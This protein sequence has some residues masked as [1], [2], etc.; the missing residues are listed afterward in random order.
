V[1]SWTLGS[2]AG[3]NTL[4]A[5]A[6]GLPSVT[7]TATGTVADTSYDIEI[8]VV[9]SMSGAVQAAFAAAEAKWESVITGDLPNINLTAAQVDACGDVTP[10]DA[11]T[12]D[13]LV[14]YARV[15][16]IDGVGKILGQAGPCYIRSIGKLPILGTMEFDEADMAAMAADGILGEVILHEM[17]HVLG[18]GTV[19]DNLSLLQGAGTADPYFSGDQAKAAYTGLGGTLVNG[20][21]LESTGEEGTR[22]SH[23][24]ETTF[25]TE[26]MTGWI[27][28]A[29]NPLSIL[30]VRSM[31][32]LGYTVNPGAADAYA[33]P[34][35][36][37]ARVSEPGPATP[38][39]RLLKPRGEV[40]PEGVRVPI[41]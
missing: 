7:F 16:P 41:R 40:T 35:P 5:S 38:W 4:T 37:P 21:P 6:A 13:D 14:I 15:A 11:L 23:W 18:F 39:E 33:L 36:S 30:T 1:G 3:T 2:S 8:R 19:W 22:D 12:V 25:R 34:A 9:G 24:R 17:G 28:G 29:G 31:G 27:L 20:V 26:L 10:A 32:D